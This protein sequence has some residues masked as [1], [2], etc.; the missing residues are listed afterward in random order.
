MV[1]LALSLLWGAFIASLVACNGAST[2]PEP[3]KNPPQNIMSLS[4]TAYD[5]VGSLVIQDGLGNQLTVTDGNFSFDAT[6]EE[7]QPYTVSIVDTP[8]SQTCEVANAQGVFADSDISGIEIRC[9]QIVIVE[10]LKLQIDVTGLTGILQLSD[11]PDSSHSVENNGLFTLGATYAP[12]ADFELVIA[13]QPQGQKCSA[14]IM[15]GMFNEVD[16]VVSIVCSD[17]DYRLNVRA[18]GLLGNIYLANERDEILTLEGEGDF[19]F[20]SS[21]EAGSKYE[22]EIR[23]DVVDQVC[24]L[25]NL[26]GEFDSA[27]I[28]L[29]ISCQATTAPDPACSPL[30][31]G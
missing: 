23:S 16:I 26:Q 12:G 3:V 1:K 6:Y 20:S 8:D 17:T 27:D 9:V 5:L 7:G 31:G 14:D 30:Q 24:V 11:M 2:E 4:G 15:A 22:V 29:L 25:E 10:D 13:Q 21:Y 28:E 18:M 19:S